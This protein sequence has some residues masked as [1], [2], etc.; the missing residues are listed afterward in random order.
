MAFLGLCTVG[1]PDHHLRSPIPTVLGRGRLEGRTDNHPEA[2]RWKFSGHNMTVVLRL[3]APE[4][5]PVFV[6]AAWMGSRSVDQ[7][8]RK[9]QTPW[10]R[11]SEPE[12]AQH[13]PDASLRGTHEIVPGHPHG[14]CGGLALQVLKW[15]SSWAGGQA[16]LSN[17][18]LPFSK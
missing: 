8:P 1:V 16:R 5:G 9:E 17:C 18:G 13:V 4:N 2:S 14:H 11:T 3:K 7:A 15:G 12:E 10:I 6:R